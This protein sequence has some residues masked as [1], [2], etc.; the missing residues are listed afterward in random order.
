MLVYLPTSRCMISVV[1]ILYNKE[2]SAMVQ[3]I[4]VSRFF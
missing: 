2:V 3:E 4:V 1:A